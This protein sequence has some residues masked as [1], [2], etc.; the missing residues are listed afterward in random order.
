MPAKAR[1]ESKLSKQTQLFG[2]KVKE[3]PKKKAGKGKNSDEAAKFTAK[4]FT[5]LVK[6]VSSGLAEAKHEQDY[7]VVRTFFSAA[8]RWL[9][10]PT[11]EANPVIGDA[12]LK[13][14]KSVFPPA[15]KPPYDDYITEYSL[16]CLSQAVED[17]RLEKDVVGEQ[18]ISCLF[19]ILRTG[20]CSTA[21]RLQIL[22]TLIQLLTK[23]NKN[24]A[25]I[26]ADAFLP[27]LKALAALMRQAGD[28]ESQISIMQILFRLLPKS[29]AGRVNFAHALGLPERLAEICGDHFHEDVR[30]F[31]KLINSG[32]DGLSKCPVFYKVREIHCLITGHL[33]PTKLKIPEGLDTFWLDF[34]VDGIS[35]EVADPD[36][37]ETISLHISY[38]KL[39]DW[40]IEEEPGGYKLF[41]ALKEPVI[42]AGPDGSQQ[43]DPPTTN[44]LTV[45]IEDDPAASAIDES[46]GRILK[47]RD[48]V[49]FDLFALPRAQLTALY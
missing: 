33:A 9:E 32:N 3:G 8:C 42:I 35:T 31:L 44:K 7:P 4:D 41:L 18:M 47:G 11:A 48:V 15:A 29:S 19:D 30:S 26:N 16:N 37:G 40:R 43:D 20:D 17:G 5:V 28:V 12:I 45:L 14:I 25:L 24:K 2:H 6:N 36:E 49:C 46:V 38:E 27:R 23:S 13:I 34:D 21:R 10:T 22:S 1:L 39:S